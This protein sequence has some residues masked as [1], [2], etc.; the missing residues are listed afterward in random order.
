MS[1]AVKRTSVLGARARNRSHAKEPRSAFRP[2]SIMRG[3]PA[4]ASCAAISNAMLFEEPVKSAVQSES[5]L[6]FTRSPPWG[7]C[8][9][10][11]SLK[12]R[13]Q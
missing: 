3:T 5:D 6:T 12:G 10:R 8:L 9:F 4:S 1:P 2:L 13:A 7:L 11:A